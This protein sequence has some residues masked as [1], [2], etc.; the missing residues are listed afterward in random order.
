[1]GAGVAADQVADRVRHRL[2]ERL[3]RPR[4]HRHAE[5]V[6]QPGDVLDD[7]PRGLTGDAHLHDPPGVAQRAQPAADLLDVGG[8]PGHHLVGAE[9][10]EQAQQVGHALGV[11]CLPVGGEPL[12]LGLELGEHRRVEQL[13]QLRASE[14]L[15]EQALVERQR[16]GPTLGERVVAFVHE[17]GDVPEEQR[18]GER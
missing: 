12:Q 6:A 11:A 13:T 15:G 4:R 18:P 8:A 16:G 2:G 7:R 9:R 10:A 17:G 1:M 14:Q 3:G 5:A